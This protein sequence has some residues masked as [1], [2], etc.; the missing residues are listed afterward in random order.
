MIAAV[1]FGLLKANLAAAAAVLVVLVLRKAVRTWFGARA[2]YVLWLAPL[3]AAAA[4]L[5]PHPQ[6][7]T[8]I[9]PMVQRA[10]TAAASV[11]DEFTVQAPAVGYPAGQ[12]ALGLLFAAWLIGA[13]AAGGLV[14]RRQARFTRSMGRLTASD[15]PKVYRAETP[16]IGP[17][18]VGV[19]RP[20]IVA[21][22]D[23]EARF[24]PQ[25][26]ALILTHE[27]VHLAGG[28]AGVNALACAAQCLSWFNPLVHLGVRLLRID[29]ELACDATVVGR[30]PEARRAY[31]ELLLKTQI[32]TQPL[33]LGC[34][35][36]AGADHPLKERIAM[37]KSPLPARA[38]RRLGAL[39]ALSACVGAAGLAWASQPERVA[40]G[41]PAATTEALLAAVP[42]N[43]HLEPAEALKYWR[44]G[45]S[46]LCKPDEHRELHNCKVTGS[47]FEAIATAAD[48]Q[49]EWPA[50][51]KKAGLTGAVTLQCSP[52][53]VTHRLDQCVGYQF[54]GAAERPEW[55]ADF[56]RAAV[57]VISIIR[58]KANPGPSDGALP[59]R[60]F[61]IMQF[62]EHPAMP[63]GPPVLVTRF[64]DFLPGPGEPADGRPAKTPA[65]YAPGSSGYTPPPGFAEPRTSA[66]AM[67]IPPFHSIWLKKPT[68]DDMVRLYPAEAVAKRLTGDVLMS[69][70]VRADGRLNSCTILHAEVS[71]DNGPPPA[72]PGFS[73]ATLQ[74]AGLFQMEPTN[75]SGQ[76]TEG[77]VVRIPVKFRLP[78]PSQPGSR[79]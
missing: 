31:A 45:L 48:A 19:F 62:N 49:R 66:Q 15:T 78:N 61:Y 57:R 79:S 23:F 36:P 18:V 34:H 64:P 47:P 12:D 28:D 38:A 41:A 52:N 76:S 33:P 20:R 67:P 5:L 60:G 1:L 69:C 8:P 68:G 42:N 44:P 9:G 22:S 63:G 2:A 21:P 40:P 11:A 54:S 59:P 10:A 71:G 70:K 27:R 32:S 37:L 39:V 26:R 58:L 29:Q 43:G 30:F 77:A 53:L 74:L 16:D 4:V 35:W 73:A 25:E 72:D 14:L 55:K 13:L 3:A 24:G 6:L 7:T 46:F 56:E 50:Q 17:A 65:S 75:S 51:A